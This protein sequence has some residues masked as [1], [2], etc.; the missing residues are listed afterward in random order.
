MAECSISGD[1]LLAFRVRGLK[2]SLRVFFTALSVLVLTLVFWNEN[3]VMLVAISG[4]IVLTTGY[5]ALRWLRYLKLPTNERFAVEDDTLIHYVGGIEK[6]RIHYSRMKGVFR[7]RHA[8][9]LRAEDSVIVPVNCEG[10]N[11]LTEALSGWGD[12]QTPPSILGDLLSVPGVGLVIL[13]LV[14]GAFVYLTAAHDM[15]L[16]A[17]L[18]AGVWAGLLVA[19]V[20]WRLAAASAKQPRPSTF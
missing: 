6:T 15:D 19:E 9:T 8:M 17:W 13:T 4:I 12:T 11:S 20:F 16:F 10:F 3:L 5:S 18:A 1:T 14:S 7:H 2:L